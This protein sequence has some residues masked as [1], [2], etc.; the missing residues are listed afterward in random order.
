MMKYFSLLILTLSILTPAFAQTTATTKEGKTVLLYEDGTWK[1]QEQSASKSSPSA[2]SE[3]DC[4]AWIETTA[5]KV[6]GKVITAAKKPI[7]VSKDQKTGFAILIMKS[8]DA[9]KVILT[10]EIVGAGTCIDKGDEI[11][12]LFR[13]GSRMTLSH[14]SEFNCVPQ[15]DIYFGDVFGKNRELKELAEKQIA[16]MRVWMRGTHVDQDFSTSQ[17][18]EFQSVIRCLSK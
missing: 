3:F 1:Y 2:G 6:S 15:A 18:D 13:D 16:T 11:N 9:L 8:S 14:A 12:I 10:I 5:D 17:S 7:V 4:S